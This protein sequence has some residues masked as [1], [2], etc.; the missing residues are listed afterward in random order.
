MQAE[1]KSHRII[2]RHLRIN[3]QKQELLDRCALDE[4]DRALEEHHAIIM[5]ERCIGLV[6]KACPQCTYDPIN[7]PKC[8]NPGYE[9]VNMYYYRVKDS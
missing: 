9:P 1:T 2:P 5:D 4:I 8:K 7:N 3:P 6:T